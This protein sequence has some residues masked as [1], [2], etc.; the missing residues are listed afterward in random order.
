MAKG[1]SAWQDDRSD[2]TT[3]NRADNGPTGER[4]MM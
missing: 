3:R 4:I 2:D 1:V